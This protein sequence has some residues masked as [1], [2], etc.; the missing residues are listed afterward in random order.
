LGK[1]LNKKGNSF[2]FYLKNLLCFFSG[3]FFAAFFS[4]T[5]AS[6]Q[7]LHDKSPIP[8]LF[9]ILKKLSP[10]Q[11]M[12]LTTSAPFIIGVFWGAF[13]EFLGAV[14]GKFQDSIGFCPVACLCACLCFLPERLPEQR[15]SVP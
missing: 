4:F 6:E 1:E 5:A 2:P 7:K 13:A 11:S 12:F 15:L 3:F 8:V 14:Q 10:E 9:Y